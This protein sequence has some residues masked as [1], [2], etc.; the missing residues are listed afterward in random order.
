MTE[1]EVWYF[2]RGSNLNIGQMMTRVGEWTVSKRAVLKGYKLKFNVR[3]ARWG[4]LT[5]N[6]VRTD[7]PRDKVYGALYRILREKLNV[8]STYEGT[9]PTDIPVEADGVNLQ[10]KTYIFET[11]RVSG[12]PPEVYL[13]VMLTGLRQHSYA[14]AVI[15]EVDKI[16]KTP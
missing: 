5:A 1:E 7:N 13:T 15:N 11:S 10:A 3:S 4:G 14:E 9:K 12:N 8:L 16:A 6:L 2:A